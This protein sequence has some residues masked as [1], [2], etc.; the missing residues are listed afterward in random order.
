MNNTSLIIRRE[1]LERVNKK[2]F[3]I[4]TILVPVVMLALMVLP[5]VLMI[6]APSSTKRIAVIDDSG[7]CLLYTSPSPRD[8]S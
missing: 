7:F 5:T 8:C 6:M 2:S 4:T 3:I 1:Y